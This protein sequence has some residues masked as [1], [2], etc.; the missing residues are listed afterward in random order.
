MSDHDPLHARLHVCITFLYRKNRFRYLFESV[1]SLAGFNVEHVEVVVC[2][3]TEDPEALAT[4]KRLLD[5]FSGSHFAIRFESFP[6][7]HQSN[8]REL[9]WMHK[10]IQRVTFA[11]TPA[12]YTHFLTLEDDI[13]FT[14]VN[15]RYFCRYRNALEIHGLIP[16]MI[17]IEFNHLAS[18]VF[19]TDQPIQ[20]T[21]S[22]QKSV[23][24]HN[25]DFVS[26][27][28]PYMAMYVF[29]R[30]L[31]EE[32]LNSRSADMEMSQQ[33]S[34]WG[35]MER[36]AMGLTWEQVPGE[37][38]SRQVV[39]IKSHTRMPHPMSWIYHMSSN[40]TNDY[41]PGPNYVFGKIRMDEIFSG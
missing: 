36:A 5:K 6:Q 19:A 35:L 26:L 23:T 24:V 21:L 25:L 11:R 33:I 16:G 2:T 39:P 31:M 14:E 1:L 20:Q 27:N 12:L 41:S 7:V 9:A 3:D 17:R 13:L 34:S 28:F 32:Y 37:F 10:S 15:F 18:D 22:E 40:F 4:L 30:A 8:P 29:D 38:I